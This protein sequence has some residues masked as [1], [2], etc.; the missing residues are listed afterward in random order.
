MVTAV[1]WVMVA[2]AARAALTFPVR[3]TAAAA[4]EAAAA[5]SAA[6]A[7]AALTILA[8]PRAVA[9]LAD[10]RTPSQARETSAHGE[11][12]KVLVVTGSSSL[13]GSDEDICV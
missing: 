2:A 11:A 1:S 9:E 8:V 10:R 5:T 13:A 7:A 12:G 3:V 4:V 6:E